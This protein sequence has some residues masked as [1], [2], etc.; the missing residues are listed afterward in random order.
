MNNRETMTI[1]IDN[2][3]AKHRIALEDML[4]HWQ[5]L[6]NIGA[7]RWTGFYADGDGDFQ[8]KITVDGREPKRFVRPDGDASHIEDG[9]GYALDPD[10][11]GWLLHDHAP[12]ELQSDD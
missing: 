6:G 5:F 9:R 4:R 2:I 8:P 11:V 7:S 12:E 3:K 1:V 10:A